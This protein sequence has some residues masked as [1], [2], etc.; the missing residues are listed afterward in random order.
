MVWK[1]S[2]TISMREKPN[3]ALRSYSKSMRNN[4]VSKAITRE[5]AGPIDITRKT[6]LGKGQHQIATGIS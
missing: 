5:R 2:L 6:R 1:N 4:S 3:S